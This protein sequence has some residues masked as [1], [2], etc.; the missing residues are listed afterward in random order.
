MIRYRQRLMLIAYLSVLLWTPPT[1][2]DAWQAR[3]EKRLAVIDQ[4]YRD[5]TDTGEIGVHVR[6]LDDGE[7]AGWRDA[8]R[9]YWASLVKVPVAVELLD[10]ISRDGADLDDTM[11]LRASD[12]VDGAGATNWAAPGTRISLRTLLERMLIDS[13]NTATDMLMR[14]VG[15]E[16][17]NRR[18]RSLMDDGIGPI[19]TL[20]DVRR[21]LY[22]VFT[23][24]AQS[25]TGM[26][27]IDLRQANFGEP[28]LVRLAQLTD[29]RREQFPP[30]DLAAAYQRY[31]AT[32]LNSG[33]LDRYADMLERINKGEALPAEATATLLSI[34]QRADTGHRR[35]TAGFQRQRPFAQK[36]G[37]QYARFCD[38]GIL[39]PGAPQAVVVVSCLRGAPSRREADRI[40][41]A[42][43][44]AVESSGVL[45]RGGTVEDP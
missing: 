25:L 15:L 31:Y 3:L 29:S 22:G 13:D 30:L 32:G 11:T 45:A 35:L 37:T 7:R 9:W 14:R 40:F 28:R 4:R 26:Q 44:R 16:A 43:G 27:L 33:R 17:V 38:A 19:T 23:P 6:R 36:T 20:I 34:M 10:R 1:L 21:H 39:D 5:H 18:A 42:I 2:A 24:R 12:Y 8:E 41:Q